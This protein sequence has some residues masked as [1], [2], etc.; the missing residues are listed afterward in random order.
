M[1]KFLNC[2]S[3][4]MMSMEDIKKGYDGHESKNVP[5]VG[6]ISDM[7]NM[8][9]KA[10]KKDP[11]GGGVPAKNLVLDGSY[12]SSYFVKL[13][14]CPSKRKEEDCK[15]KRYSWMYNR[16]WKPRYGFIK[17]KGGSSF[18]N[19][20]IFSILK[21][22]MDLNPL[23]IIVI[24]M[25]GKSAGGSFIAATCDELVADEKDIK[26]GFENRVVYNK[27]LKTVHI[28]FVLGCLILLLLIIKF[29]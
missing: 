21:S 18:G 9:G 29:L 15:D 6:F 24:M 5:Y 17:N 7:N 27:V 22:I 13:G 12:S 4:M 10:S 1:A 26:E 11:N 20:I 8:I 23:E 14:S 16:C 28:L 3:S 25:S 19:G 2:D